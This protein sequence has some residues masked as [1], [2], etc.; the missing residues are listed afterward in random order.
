MY[1]ER[2]LRSN[3]QPLVPDRLLARVAVPV[4]LSSVSIERGSGLLQPDLQPTSVR[5][6]HLLLLQRFHTRK[7]SDRLVEVHR[8]RAMLRRVQ[9]E[10]EGL[11]QLQ[12]FLVKLFD[13]F[14]GQFIHG[15]SV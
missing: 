1:A 15:S 11:D 2:R 9:L 10:F 6:G 14:V 12:K 13:L 7:A 3:A 8:L 5:A 4:L